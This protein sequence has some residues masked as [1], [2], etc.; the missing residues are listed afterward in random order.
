MLTRNP[1]DSV[2]PPRAERQEVRPLG[3]DEIHRLL[4]AADATPHGALVHMALMTGLRQG[5][6]LGL[7]WQDID[8][9]AGMLHVQQTA[10]WLAV[11]SSSAS[12]RRPR[13][14]A[15]S[16]SPP[17]LCRGYERIASSS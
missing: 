5:E 14:A 16:P 12:Q 11:G 2:Q 7:R 9:K 4:L 15:L 1:A 10:Q 6:L 8:L 13:A 3:P 17:I